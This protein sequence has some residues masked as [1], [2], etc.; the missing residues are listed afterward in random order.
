[1]NKWEPALYLETMKTQKLHKK[2]K[3]AFRQG[4]TGRAEVLPAVLR[5]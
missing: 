3:V 1:M 2:L 5:V 4:K